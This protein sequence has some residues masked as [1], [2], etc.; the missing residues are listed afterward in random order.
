MSR[1]RFEDLEIWKRGADAGLRLFRVAD[2]LDA[3][4]KYRFAEQL[5]AAGLSITNNIA[6]GSGSD[7]NKDFARFVGY[8][9]KSTFECANMTIMFQRD[10]L[11]SATRT[12][13]L[14][15]E[16]EQLSRMQFAFIKKLREQ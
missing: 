10:E 16:L 3:K 9:R 11:L 15:D 7:S 14:L 2:F 13:G 12:D 8:A 1:F 4:K 5:R 6:E